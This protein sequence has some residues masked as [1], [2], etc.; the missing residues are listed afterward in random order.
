MPTSDLLNAGKFISWGDVENITLSSFNLRIKHSKTNQFG[1]R[2][3]VLPF[4][5]CA[6][7]KLCPVRALLAHFGSSTLPASRPLFNFMEAGSEVNFTHALLVKKLKSGLVRTQYAGSDL[8]CHSFRRGGA[9]FAFSL[10]LSSTEIK[11]RG[12][13]RSSAYERYLVVSSDSILRTAKILS[14]G[15]GELGIV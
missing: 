8:S 3:L 14:I 2:Q 15:A 5:A 1:Q 4:V 12:D 11:L 6:D 13:R 7:P 10:G 9:T